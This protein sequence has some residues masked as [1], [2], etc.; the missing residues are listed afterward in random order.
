MAP[1]AVLFW[2]GNI[3]FD[4]VGQLSIK[5]AAVDPESL[6]GFARWRRVFGNRWIWV[7]VSAYVT[8]FLLWLAF[9]S[10]VPL[11]QAVLVG[12]VNILAV[13]LGGRIFFAEKL[14]PRRTAAALLIAFGVALVGWG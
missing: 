14:T 7:G 10:L 3:L 6:S 8:E 2:I 12:S 4:T 11:S 13:M 5:A 1:Q 9:L